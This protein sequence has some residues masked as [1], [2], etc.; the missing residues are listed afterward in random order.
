[1]TAGGGHPPLPRGGVDSADEVIA[2]PIDKRDERLGGR[3]A[4]R[5]P[6]AGGEIIEAILDGRQPAGLQLDALM[7]PMPHDWAAQRAAL[8]L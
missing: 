4:E 7:K 1:M 8:G 3:L 6:R 5:G 2:D